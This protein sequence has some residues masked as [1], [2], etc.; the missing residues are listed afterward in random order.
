M[1]WYVEGLIDCVVG[2][3]YGG[4]VFLAEFAEGDEEFVVHSVHIVE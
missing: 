4:S 2:S 3:L 1:A